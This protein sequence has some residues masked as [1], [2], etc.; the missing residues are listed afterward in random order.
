MR[1]S[2][3]H[4]A[5]FVRDAIFPHCTLVCVATLPRG[6]RAKTSKTERMNTGNQR[7]LA[8]T[9]KRWGMCS[10]KEVTIE[11]TWKR[12][13]S[14]LHSWQNSDPAAICTQQRSTVDT[15]IAEMW[16]CW[17]HGKPMEYTCSYGDIEPSSSPSP[18]LSPSKGIPILYTKLCS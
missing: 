16:I 15:Y 9:W 18:F 17:S 13:D 7:N 3:K 11:T 10:V 4:S 6:A 5:L 1:I 12:P 14:V 2:N 8:G